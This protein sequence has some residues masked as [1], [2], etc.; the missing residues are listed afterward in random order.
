M[1]G[2][3]RGSQLIRA[4][5]LVSILMLLQTRGKVT[6]VEVA[7]EL[8]VSERTARRDLDALGQAGLPVYSRP[9]RHGGWE[10]LGGGR[11]DL[12][13]LTA[14]EARALFLVAGPAPPTPA[15]KAALRKLVRALPEPMRG[16]AEAAAHAIVIDP[17]GWDR[18]SPTVRP[19]FLDEVQRAVIESEQLD[20]G[21]VAH[22]GR[23][24]TR[25]VHP[26]GL[27]A[28]GARWY[29]IADTAEGLRTFRV[30]R[31][32][33]VACTATRVARPEGFVLE[34]AWRLIADR[35]DAIRA[36]VTARALI[37]P[38]MLSVMRMLLG[39]RVH[40]GAGTADGRIELMLRGHSE[41]S[42]AGEIA[43][44]GA[45]LEVLEPEGVRAALVTVGREL[46]AR[47]DAAP[48][49][50]TGSERGDAVS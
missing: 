23:Q 50:S 38:S 36:P 45:A 25:R 26:L 10:L 31:I 12:T 27:A 9:G 19:R 49:S 44:I 41:R 3:G 7:R 29:L 21:Y 24:S 48:V 11:T 20:L 32:I 18:K 1:T 22:D 35:V 40:I 5:R 17:A 39:E 14:A 2:L 33:D 13:G 42:L 47:Y 46:I 43:G 15:L 8:E 30:D 28:K 16:E 37:D 4:D 34:D 6:A